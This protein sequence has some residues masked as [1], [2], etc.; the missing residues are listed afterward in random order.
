MR[1]TS[2]GEGPEN[3]ISSPPCSS[4]EAQR[5]GKVANARAS[6]E[7]RL[8]QLD[9]EQAGLDEAERAAWRTWAQN[10]AD[11]PPPAPLTSERDAIAKERA[12][13][14]PALAAALN[15]ERAVVPRLAA[16]HAELR[17]IG[18]KIFEQ[19]IETLLDE[20]IEINEGVHAA[21]AEFLRACEKQD[22][23]RD[24][25]VEAVARAVNSNDRER[26]SVLRGALSQLERLER[27]MLAGDPG[28]RARWASEFR[29]RL[30]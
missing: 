15:G 24:A 17:D 16:L 20:A 7:R 30:A 5:L 9:Q 19:H 1:R 18:V 21:A 14:A 2:S 13:A 6:I 12:L 27:P 10:D 25:M 22:G 23:L 8:Q 4:A 28:S 26:E 29:R 11:G 3:S